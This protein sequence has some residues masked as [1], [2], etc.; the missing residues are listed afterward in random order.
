MRIVVV[1][2]T[3]NFGTSVLDAL[4]D[5]PAVDD[6]IGLARRLPQRRWPK[7]RFVACDLRTDALEPH[8]VGADAVVHLAWFFLPSHRPDI[9]WRNNVYGS[10]RL[11][12]AV[13]RAEVPTLV[14]ASSIGAYS[15]ADG[16]VVDERWPTHSRPGSAYGREKAYVERML[17]AFEARHP[18]VRVVRLR[19]AFLFKR[20]AASEQLRIFAG[21]FAPRLPRR[22]V[23]VLPY[24]HGLRFAVLHTDDAAAA[25]R[26]AVRAEHA[27]GAF[28]LATSPIVDGPMLAD[29]L[30]ARLLTVPPWLTRTA[31]AVA[32]HLRIVPTEPGLFDLLRTAPLLDVER[33]RVELGWQPSRSSADAIR[34][35]LSGA[36]DGSGDDTPP[37][38]PDGL[39]IRAREIAAGVGGR[40]AG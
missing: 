28:N 18:S 1:G 39:G 19:P 30:G 9:T 27:T 4:A 3:G 40:V 12:E 23:P 15:P 2:A 37:L 34:A 22:G 29:L 36:S 24:P 25:V 33:A 38:A 13:A 5:D 17:D 32:W 8:F 31:A 35:L 26:L 20:A 6:V 11:F 16:A 21:P 14:Y 7:T 10:E